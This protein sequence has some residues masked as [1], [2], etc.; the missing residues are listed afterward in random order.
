MLFNKK[1]CLEHSIVYVVLFWEPPHSLV[2]IRAPLIN[3]QQHY[4]ITLDSEQIILFDRTHLRMCLRKLQ[5]W[6]IQSCRSCWGRFL[7][8]MCIGYSPSV[9][10]TWIQYNFLLFIASVNTVSSSGHFKSSQQCQIVKSTNNI[11][12]K[13]SWFYTQL[14]SI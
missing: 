11:Q 9:V 14:F 3:D 8:E 7:S 6:N 10:F 1:N 12:T 5:E 2:P 13:K 4:G